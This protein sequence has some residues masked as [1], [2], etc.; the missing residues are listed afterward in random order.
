MTKVK[1]KWPGPRI[2]FGFLDCPGCK[3]RI[4]AQNCPPLHAELMEA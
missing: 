4:K 1:G 2:V 3:G